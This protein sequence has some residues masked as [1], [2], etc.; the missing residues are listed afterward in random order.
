MDLDPATAAYQKHGYNELPVEARLGPHRFRIPANYFRDQ[1][2]PDFQGGWELMVQ[3]P[4][5]EPL[6]PGKRSGQSFETFEKTISIS[7][8]YVD[9]VPIETLMEA[10]ANVDEAGEPPE[11]QDPSD[12]LYLMLAQPERNGLIPYIVDQKALDAYADAEAFRLGMT[13]RPTGR[14]S[15]KDWFVRRD[16]DGRLQTL[17]RCDHER[18]PGEESNPVCDHS[19]V[20]PDLNAVVRISY[21]RDYLASWERIENKARELIGQ[22]RVD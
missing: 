20:I 5:L 17:I 15:Y 7:P 16:A 2:G 22:L 4:D 12:R 6:P 3:W 19:F 10:Y 8:D 13:R 21:L 18:E 14:E 1:I 9:R 11:R